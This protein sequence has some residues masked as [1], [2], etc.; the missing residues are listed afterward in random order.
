LVPIL[1]LEHFHRPCRRRRRPEEEE[2]RRRRRRRRR[3][4]R[5]RRRRRGDAVRGYDLLEGHNGS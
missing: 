1:V 2:A 5:R 4:R 3:G